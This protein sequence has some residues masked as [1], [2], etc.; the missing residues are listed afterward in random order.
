MIRFRALWISAAL[1]V[2]VVATTIPTMAFAQTANIIIGSGSAPTDP[3]T[4]SPASAVTLDDFYLRGGVVLDWSEETRFTDKDCAS[5]SPAALY[6]CGKGIDGAPRSS[7][8][9][10]GTMAGFELGVGYVAAPVLRLEAV[11]QYRPKFFF[12]G[13]ANFLQTTDRQAVSADLSSL[14]GVLAAYLDLPGLGPLNPFLGSGG[15]LARINIDDTRMEF[16]KTT[17]I[18][19][20]GQRVNFTLMLTAG[21]ATSPWKKMALDLAWR[22]TDSGAVETGKARGRIVWRD[23]SRDPLEIDL[24]ETRTNLSGHG[25]WVSLRYAF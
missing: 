10:F 7:L 15:G 17:T 12:E 20:G 19:P 25:L 24:A 3:P 4:M 6:G 2:A 23:G 18:V 5:I 22:Y 14:S 16:P 8:G 1:V 9:D 11:L 13:R 21:V